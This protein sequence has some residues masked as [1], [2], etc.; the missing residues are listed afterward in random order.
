MRFSV[1]EPGQ[2][3]L[4]ITFDVASAFFAGQD[5]ILVQEAAGICYSKLKDILNAEFETAIG[6]GI[7]VTAGDILQYRRLSAS[8]NRN[9]RPRA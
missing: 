6:G 5:R 9:E 4:L 3:Q 1:D 8:R 2:K 7:V